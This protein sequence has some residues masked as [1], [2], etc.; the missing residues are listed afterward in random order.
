M[1]VIFVPT[2]LASMCPAASSRILRVDLRDSRMME[3]FG[4]GEFACARSVCSSAVNSAR[5]RPSGGDSRTL[6]SIAFTSCFDIERLR[7]DLRRTARMLL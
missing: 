4:L 6:A 7:D 1:P 3:T 5:D 2:S